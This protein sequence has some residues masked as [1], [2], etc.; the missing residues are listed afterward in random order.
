MKPETPD[1]AAEAFKEYLR[2]P[3][4]YRL[5]QLIR[6]AGGTFSVS[7]PT[8][9]PS[10]AESPGERA[11][12]EVNGLD[13]HQVD[14]YAVDP[15]NDAY[16]PPAQ[17]VYIR[18][19]K[20]KRD[21]F[22]AADQT[23]GGRYLPMSEGDV[24]QEGDQVYAQDKWG[25]VAEHIIGKKLGEGFFGLQTHLYRRPVK[26]ETP[27]YAAEAKELIQSMFSHFQNERDTDLDKFVDLIIK[28]AKQP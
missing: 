16:I 15:S 2:S 1:Y 24:F 27:D 22:N 21:E 28:A 11:L 10:R 25:G 6:S 3:E 7:F 8:T 23:C 12:L 20:R 4:H 5:K 14:P 13:G 17:L 19:R 9:L 18:E 26:P